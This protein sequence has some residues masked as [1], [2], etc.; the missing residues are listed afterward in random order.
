[1]MNN[2]TVISSDRLGFQSNPCSLIVAGT[3]SNAQPNTKDTR[4]VLLK[5]TY[6]ES[7]VLPI[8]MLQET[9]KIRIVKDGSYG[10]EKLEFV[11]APLNIKIIEADSVLQ[12]PPDPSIKLKAMAMHKAKLEEELAA[13]KKEIEAS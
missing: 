10:S 12:P 5:P 8:E 1:M 6:G 3:L 2:S 13:L 7:F 9:R 11:A 4:L